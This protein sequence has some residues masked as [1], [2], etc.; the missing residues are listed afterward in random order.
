M[1][2]TASPLPATLGPRQVRK[3]RRR[4]RMARRT[5]TLRKPNSETAACMLQ[6]ADVFRRNGRG[7]L[8]KPETRLERDRCRAG[9][10][11]FGL[12]DRIFLP[13]RSDSAS[14]NLGRC[15]TVARRQVVQSAGR[16]GQSDPGVGLQK[17]AKVGFRSPFNDRPGAFTT[18]SHKVSFTP[19]DR[20]VDLVVNEVLKGWSVQTFV[21]AITVDDKLQPLFSVSFHCCLCRTH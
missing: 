5:G 13:T 15:C 2:R 9:G 1:S 16:N 8:A 17:E 11:I 14:F 21:T 3:R 20:I 19:R 7:H 4:L 18:L 6:R 12:R 10:G